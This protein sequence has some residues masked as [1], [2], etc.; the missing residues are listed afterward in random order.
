MP[1]QV[2]KI[3]GPLVPGECPH[4]HDLIEGTNEGCSNRTCPMIQHC[5]NAGCEAP[6]APPNGPNMF[7][8]VYYGWAIEISAIV[9]CVLAYLLLRR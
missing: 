2:I 7:R 4:C 6:R 9:F 5:D 1:P 8:G 3:Y